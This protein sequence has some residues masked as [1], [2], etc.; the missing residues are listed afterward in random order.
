DSLDVKFAVYA[1]PT[2]AMPL[3]SEVHTVSFDEGYFSVQLGDATPFA[4]TFDGSVRYLGVTVGT[5][6]EMTPR[7]QVGSVPYALLA[8][9]VKGDIHPTSVW[10][11]GFGQVID[12]NGQWVGDPTGLEGPAGPTGPMG[13]QGQPGLDGAVGPVGPTGPAGLQG[14]TGPTG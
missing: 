4:D 2:A 6:P 11:D 3:W 1:S 8:G 10:I 12:V 13:V 14:A 7:A 9:D 5:D